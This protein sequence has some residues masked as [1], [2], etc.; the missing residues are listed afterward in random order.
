MVILLQVVAAAAAAT[1]TPA[2]DIFK[3]STADT[4]GIAELST[5][6]LVLSVTA[7]LLSTVLLGVQEQHSRL[8]F[9]IKITTFCVDTLFCL[10]NKI[11]CHHATV[12]HIRM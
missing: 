3:V 8:G 12:S 4:K 2:V 11:P 10:R 1:M 9:Q 7:G 6:V 5:I